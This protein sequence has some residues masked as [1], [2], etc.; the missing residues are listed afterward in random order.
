M[1]RE[2]DVWSPTVKI[3]RVAQRRDN[4]CGVAV[5]AMACGVDYDAIAPIL[6]E[7]WSDKGINDL[8]VKDWLINNGWAWQEVTMFHPVKGK[9][10]KRVPWPPKPFARSH[11]AQVIVSAGAHF[12]VMDSTGEVFDPWSADRK[13]LTHPDYKQ[14]SY[15][16][17]LWK[18]VA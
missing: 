4:D 3:T 17:G 6:S 5:L 11:I 15:V 12:T 18:V 8:H 14:V 7:Y 9:Y 2:P 13:S 1:G 16:L 10:E